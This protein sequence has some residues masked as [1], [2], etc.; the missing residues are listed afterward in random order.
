[1]KPPIEIKESEIRATIFENGDIFVHTNG[2]IH[3]LKAKLI[4][5]DRG[6]INVEWLKWT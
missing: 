2:D 3:I 5:D 6:I 4:F 1:M